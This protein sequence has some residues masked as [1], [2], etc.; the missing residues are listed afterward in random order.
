M[1]YVNWLKADVLVGEALVD[2]V[3]VVVAL[4]DVVEVVVA[5]RFLWTRDL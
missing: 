5:S 2:V 3:E 1:K 4:V